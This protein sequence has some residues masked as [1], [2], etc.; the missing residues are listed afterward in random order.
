MDRGFR[1]EI[2]LFP[3]S[4]ISTQA[5]M[6][7]LIPYLAYGGRIGQGRKRGLDR[8]LLLKYC[9]FASETAWHTVRK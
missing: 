4:H 9:I 6:L 3:I 5:Y 7:L 1:V 2:Y 8:G